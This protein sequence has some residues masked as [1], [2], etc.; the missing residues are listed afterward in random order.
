MPQEFIYH[1]SSSTVRQD[2][3]PGSSLF[4]YGDGSEEE[5]KSI[6]HIHWRGNRP[7]TQLDL[8]CAVSRQGA[9][10]SR[11]DNT[12]GMH[13]PIYTPKSLHASSQSLCERQQPGPHSDLLLLI[14]QR[15]FTL[16][17]APA[18]MLMNGTCLS[19]YRRIWQITGTEVSGTAS[20]SAESMGDE[21][22]LLLDKPKCF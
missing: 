8:T 17:Q 3:E 1:L 19:S 16:Y 6:R 9:W 10:Q 14:E 15:L 21:M 5:S 11:K 4:S 18:V 22:I 12:S 2:Q 20:A 13:M 7:G